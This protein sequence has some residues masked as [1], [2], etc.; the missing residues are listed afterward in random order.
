MFHFFPS[1]NFDNVR[2]QSARAP[3]Q[4]GDAQVSPQERTFDSDN[5]VRGGR[6]H[7]RARTFRN[8]RNFS[9]DRPNY[10]E[11]EGGT[12]QDDYRHNRRQHD[13][14]PRSNVSSVFE[15]ICDASVPT[16]KCRMTF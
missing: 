14:Q 2:S 3:G 9:G 16:R 4:E 7:H 13:R 5:T 6:G 15:I 11:R 8:S 12:G 10:Y 1:S